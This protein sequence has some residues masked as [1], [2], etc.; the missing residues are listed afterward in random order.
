MKPAL[1]LA[2]MHSVIVNSWAQPCKQTARL[3]AEYYVAVYAQHYRVPGALVRAIIQRESDWRP[4]AVSPKGAVGVMQ[5][6]PLTAA[7]LGVHDRCDIAENVAGGVRY[8]AWLLRKFGGDPRLAAAAYIGGEAVIARR[9]LRYRNREVLAY[10]SRIRESYQQ[11]LAGRTP[12][13]CPSH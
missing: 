11:Q 2:L 6:M 13:P 1:I 7:R 3:E 8:L 9:G 12:G 10:V 4:C 5:L